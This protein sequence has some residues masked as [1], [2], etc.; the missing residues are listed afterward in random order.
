MRELNK[1]DD[2]L[3]IVKLEKYF[4]LMRKTHFRL[5]RLL[6]IIVREG[7]LEREEGETIKK[8]LENIENNARQIARTAETILD[9]TQKNQLDDVLE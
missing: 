2:R 5:C 1:T 7:L 4:P 8:L 3:E 9:T 6:T